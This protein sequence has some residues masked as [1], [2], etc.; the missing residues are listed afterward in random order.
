MDRDAVFDLAGGQQARAH[1]TRGVQKI[2]GDRCRTA[3]YTVNAGLARVLHHATLGVHGDVALHVG[4]AGQHPQGRAV[5]LRWHHAGF[6]GKRHDGGEH[7]AAV[8]R[9]V[10]GVLVGLQLGEQKIEVHAGHRAA[11]HDSYLAGQRVGTAHAVDLACIRAAQGG[12][13]H[14]VACGNVLGQVGRIEKRALGGSAPHEQ[15]GNSSLRRSGHG[16]KARQKWMR[17]L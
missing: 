6:Q 4:I 3:R 1:R 16:H 9:G 14:P 13:Q 2:D 17:A 7:I 12:Q 5:A 10:H 11:A 8:G 15:T